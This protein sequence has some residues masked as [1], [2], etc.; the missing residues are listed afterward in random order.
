[1]KEQVNKRFLKRIKDIPAERL[2]SAV[3][4]FLGIV[5]GI[6]VRW[7]FISGSDFPVND[8]GFFYQM[9]VDLIENHY[10][11]PMYTT[12]NQANIPFAYPPLGFYLIAGIHTLT[13]IPV[14][15]LLTYSP[16]VISV[17]TIP[18]CYQFTK[19]FFGEKIFLR[20]LAT[21]IF[22]TLPRS[23]EWFVMGGGIT[24]SL[25]F[26]FALLALIYA[27]KEFQERNLTAN[28]LITALF[29]CLTIL[30]HPVATLFLAFGMVVLFIYYW[31]VTIAKPLLVVLVAVLA[32]APWWIVV[33][34]KHG[35][36]PYVGATNA[37]HVN[38]YE[39]KYIIT[40]NFEYENRFFLPLVSALAII[41][42]FS[43][44]RKRS[45]FLGILVWMGYF[46]IPR[47]GV[48]FLTVYLAM[49]SAVG[50]SVV[51]SSWQKPFYPQQDYLQNRFSLARGTKILLFYL[52]IYVFLGSFTYKYVDNKVDLRLS[53]YDRDAM[54][55]IDQNADVSSRIL[56]VPSAEPRRNWWNDYIGEWL[57]AISR[58]EN[59]STVQGYE[60]IP[61][62]FQ[63]RIVQ[64]F[65]LRK[66][67]EI[68]LTCI[69]EW[70]RNNQIQANYLYISK[71]EQSVLFVENI[72]ASPRYVKAFENKDVVIVQVLN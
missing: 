19:I 70:Q 3:L 5:Y 30:S 22:A 18:V 32:S 17:A 37:G 48:D 53:E 66:C 21:Y 51:A 59:V 62:R 44:D 50:F 1:M 13:A 58:R 28:L 4:L 52:A 72:L 41:G 2:I 24:R 9:I 11:L 40:Q 47:G 39:L 20:A 55:W 43:P 46:V 67:A 8:G 57:P 64:Y 35:L 65:G 10:R 71:K 26:I 36:S 34:A 31:P 56:H 27:S 23:F 14:V 69:E 15:K 16:F 49:L 25:G 38:W 29:S 61:D 68:G 54:T 60:W 42:L 33:L 63:G 6:S 12:Y 45:L 7:N